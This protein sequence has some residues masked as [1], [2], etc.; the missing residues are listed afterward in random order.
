MNNAHVYHPLEIRPSFVTDIIV[1]IVYFDEIDVLLEFMIEYVVILDNHC[2]GVV[3]L[4]PSLRVPKFSIGWMSEELTNFHIAL[5]VVI[6][7]HYIGFDLSDVLAEFAIWYCVRHGWWI[8]RI[9]SP[10]L[11]FWAINIYA[12]PEQP[13]LEICPRL[14]W[15]ENKSLFTYYFR[16]STQHERIIR[17]RCTPISCI[18]LLPYYVT[19]CSSPLFGFIRQEMRSS[20]LL[21]VFFRAIAQYYIFILTQRLKSLNTWLHKPVSESYPSVSVFSLSFQ[22]TSWFS[23]ERYLATLEQPFRLNNIWFKYIRTYSTAQ[24]QRSL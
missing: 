13:E 24:V 22:S 7:C 3:I 1:C 5:P 21:Y 4:A 23:G 15:T 9:R 8:S 19:K 6:V 12:Y 18:A 2:D 16:H 10:P 20:S 14:Q 11:A 17:N